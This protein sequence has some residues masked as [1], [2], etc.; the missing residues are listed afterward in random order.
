MIGHVV[1]FLL[2]DA[3]IEYALSLIVSFINLSLLLLALNLVD[4]TD[5]DLID[6]LFGHL[7]GLC[8]IQS[9]RVN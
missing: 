7:K 4:S 8:L 2:S 5:W 6:K 9:V 3:T 1:D